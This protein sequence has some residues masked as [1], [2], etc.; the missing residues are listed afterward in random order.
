MRKGRSHHVAIVAMALAAQLGTVGCAS[1]NKTAK[2]GVIGAGAGGV[3]GAAV[4][5]ATGNVARG[6]IIGAAVGGAAGAIIGHQMD[7]QAQEIAATVPG[8]T[9]TRVGEGMVVTF[10]SGILFDYDRSDLR[11]N[12]RGNLGNLAQSL[13]KYPGEEVLVIGHT[14]AQGSDSYNQALSERRAQSAAGY[15]QAQ[16]IAS[17]RIHTR[18]MGEGDP[19]A[20]N[21]TDA[22][23]QANR[24]VEV[25]LYA[26]EAWR[27]QAQQSSSSGR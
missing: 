22:G 9:V 27:K 13:Q 24:R 4:G 15:L 7:K 17:S 18:G 3:I 20:D 8:A 25:V 1:M 6:A 19:V 11:A 16:G 10:D 23:R 21:S 5:K 2:G 26:G 14:D 12:A